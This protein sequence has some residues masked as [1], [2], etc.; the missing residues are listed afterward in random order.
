ML[1]AKNV[2]RGM[3]QVKNCYGINVQLKMW[4]INGKLISLA[5]VTKFFRQF[6]LVEKPWPEAERDFR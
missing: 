3:K 2:I 4:I 1:I 5:R 6:S